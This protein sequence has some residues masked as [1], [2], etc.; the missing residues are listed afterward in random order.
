MVVDR[1]AEEDNPMLLSEIGIEPLTIRP[2]IAMVIEAVEPVAESS[3]EFLCRNDFGSE[4]VPRH[5]LVSPEAAP[6]P[7][8]TALPAQPKG[9]AL[10]RYKR[11]S[12]RS[13]SID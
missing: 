2:I 10:N 1:V 4:R 8:D 7:P 13:R 9:C 6:R 11:R 12:P 5:G 3:R